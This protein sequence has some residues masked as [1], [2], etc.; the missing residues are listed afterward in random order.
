MSLASLSLVALAPLLLGA[1]PRQEVRT[2]PRLVAEVLPPDAQAGMG[3]GHA[4]ALDQ[5]TL[6]VGAPDFDAIPGFLTSSGA[7]L[8]FERRDDGWAFV[9][10]L[11][12][13]A[14]LQGGSF[15]YAVALDGLRLAV[16][17]PGGTTVRLFERHPSEPGSWQLVRELSESFYLAYGAGLALQGNLLVIGAPGRGAPVNLGRPDG[18]VTLHDRNAGG[19]NAWGEVL[20]LDGGRCSGTGVSVDVDGDRV[21]VGAPGGSPFASCDP[22]YGGPLPPKAY[23]LEKSGETWEL[24]QVLDPALGGAPFTAHSVALS[25]D[26]L[27]LESRSGAV[28]FERI[29]S[30]WI[31][32][33]VVPRPSPLAGGLRLALDGDRLAIGFPSGRFAGV[34]SGLVHLHERDH[35]GSEAWGEVQRLGRRGGAAGDRLG[36][37]LSSSGSLLAVGAP[38]D[39]RAATDAGAVLIFADSLALPGATP[40]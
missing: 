11:L 27:A 30:I 36:Q 12:P 9:Q 39:D 26:T 15:G 6:V 3:F 16:G 1:S 29:G 14:P 40:R 38:L 21:L 34:G 35:G 13:P 32:A 8:V 25:G 2:A 18:I 7:V 22:A 4:V 37:A 20:R 24:A 10:R 31:E 23:L 33:L 17:E 5:D 19:P 28:L